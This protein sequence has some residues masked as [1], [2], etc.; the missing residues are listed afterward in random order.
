MNFVHF[1]APE[2]F[3]KYYGETEKIIRQIFSKARE[4]EPC[5]LVFDEIDSIGSSRG[6]S[7]TD[8]GTSSRVLTQL[9]TEMDGIQERKQIILIGCTNQIDSIDEALLRPGRLD[10]LIFIDYPDKNDRKEILKG[11]QCKMPFDKDVDFEELC[12]DTEGMSCSKIVSLCNE[13][14]ISS[15]RDNI[16]NT[17][18]QRKHFKF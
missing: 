2:L 6:N 3:S 15:L 10:Q 14:A 5:V 4:L 11:L 17:K 13:A 16:E 7:D 1:K 8:S 9:L 12:E 18:I